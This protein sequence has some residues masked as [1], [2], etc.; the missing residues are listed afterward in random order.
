MQKSAKLQDKMQIREDKWTKLNV[1]VEV[2]KSTRIVA[3]ETNNINGL[4]D[5]TKSQNMNN[6]AFRYKLDTSDQTWKTLIY[7]AELEF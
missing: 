3:V 5:F 7:K 6:S 4:R 2:V 1:H